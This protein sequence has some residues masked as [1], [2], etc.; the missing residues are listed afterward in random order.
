[1]HLPI[2]AFL[3]MFFSP[4]APSQDF[5]AA[6]SSPTILPHI[7]ADKKDLL[8]WAM[9]TR[10]PGCMNTVSIVQTDAYAVADGQESGSEQF[11]PSVRNHQ[12]Q[13]AGCNAR[14]GG[15]CC[16]VKLFLNVDLRVRAGRG[17]ADR[18]AR[19]RSNLDAILAVALRRVS[20][21]FCT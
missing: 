14:R 12:H 7:P 19:W 13:Q 16:S 2:S 15:I 9:Q 11:H 20:C 1:M 5:Q 17:R 3:A 18:A 21:L 8:G 4:P 10:K 6:S